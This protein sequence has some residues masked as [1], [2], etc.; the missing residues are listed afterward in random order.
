LVFLVG[1][2]SGVSGD[3]KTSRNVFHAKKTPAV[4]L[5]VLK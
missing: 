3:G 1:G 5:A 2:T 4:L